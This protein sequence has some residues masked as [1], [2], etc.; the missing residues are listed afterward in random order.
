MQSF[1]RAYDGQR[2]WF[3][4]GTFLEGHEGTGEV[5]RTVDTS[6]ADFLQSL[7]PQLLNNTVVMMLSDHGLHMGLN[8]VY[9]I[10]GRIEHM[11]PFLAMLV[12]PWLTR[13]YPDI[14]TALTANQQKLT[15]GYDVFTTLNH[16]LH[17]DGSSS[18]KLRQQFPRWHKA[19][20]YGNATFTASLLGSIPEGRQC[21]DMPMPEQYCRCFAGQHQFVADFSQD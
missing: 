18:A 12:P 14:A 16:I 9:S 5:I 10:N 13:R 7:T 3:L 20:G 17:F 11:N 6:M 1:L 15:S 4:S 21:A 2:P 8:F 19:S